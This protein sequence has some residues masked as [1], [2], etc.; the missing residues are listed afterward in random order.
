M[1]TLGT[2]SPWLDCP[3]RERLNKRH[4]T[5]T[6]H[7]YSIAKQHGRRKASNIGS[8]ILY[9]V[10]CKLRNGVN[11]SLVTTANNGYLLILGTS[12]INCES[13]NSVGRFIG[14]VHVHRSSSGTAVCGSLL[15]VAFFIHYGLIDVWLLL[16]S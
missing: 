12:S 8:C 13:S 7:S 3:F 11:T 16:L 6:D 5:S 15:C 9:S 2:N 14:R 10:L 4:T 1:E